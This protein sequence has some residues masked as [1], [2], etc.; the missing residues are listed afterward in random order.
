MTQWLESKMREPAN[1]KFAGALKQL[2]SQNVFD[3]DCKGNKACLVGFLPH[4]LDSSVDER[5]KMIANLQEAA[6]KVAAL[7]VRLIWS[8][9]GD[10][11]ELEKAVDAGGS[12]YPSLVAF[13]GKK[14]I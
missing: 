2:I 9:A 7:G 3:K 4:L 12:G 14:L 5:N 10:H 11:P 6:G 13:N 8:V 1:K